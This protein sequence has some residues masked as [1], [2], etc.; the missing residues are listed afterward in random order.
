MVA[1]FLVRIYCSVSLI[2]AAMGHGARM[3]P[4]ELPSQRDGAGGW[5]TGKVSPK[6]MVARRVRMLWG[7]LYREADRRDVTAGN[8]EEP[9]ER[10]NRKEDVERSEAEGD[11]CSSP[12]TDDDFLELEDEIWPKDMEDV[13]GGAIMAD[14]LQLVGEWPNKHQQSLGGWISGHEGGGRSKRL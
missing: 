11:Y 9:N 1:Y 13:D 3:L 4:A 14:S 7:S 10:V 8:G 5:D 12:D 6:R 2:P